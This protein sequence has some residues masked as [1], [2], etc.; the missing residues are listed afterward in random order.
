MPHDRLGREI[1]VGD[2]VCIEYIV[3]SISPND[4]FCNATLKTVFPAKPSTM[5]TTMTTNSS[6]C[7]RMRSAAEILEERALADHYDEEYYAQ[8]DAI[9][10]QMI[11]AMSTEG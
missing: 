5:S 7:Q 8:G 1:Q 9:V 3:E 6:V 10:D 2:R 4:E 11:E